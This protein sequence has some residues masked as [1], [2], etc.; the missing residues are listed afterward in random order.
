MS[1]GKLF[2]II[3]GTALLGIAPFG[4][5]GF[6]RVKIEVVD[7]A[8]VKTAIQPAYNA[9]VKPASRAAIK[10]FRIPI[11]HETIEIAPGVKY[12]GW[13]FGGTVPG[14]VIRVR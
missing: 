7:F 9:A 6:N 1:K 8:K 3:A 5:A 12:E 2:G 13:T 11:T 14:P 4:F 10:E